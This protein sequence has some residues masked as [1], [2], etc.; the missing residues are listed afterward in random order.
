MRS[1]DRLLLEGMEFYGYHG[2]IEAERDL[3]A[4]YAVDV[5]IE[6]DLAPAGRSDDLADTIDYVRCFQLVR[7]VV[8]N[9]Q[10][11]L[12]EALAQAVADALLEV[13]RTL[14]VTVRIAKQPPVRGVFTRFA[15]TV[16][17][18]RDPEG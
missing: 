5:A 16:E 1:P 9:R 13:P 4:R 12:L 10:Y 14:A 6:A 8:E 3:G 18:R 2:D 15:V 17:R 11:R 7:D